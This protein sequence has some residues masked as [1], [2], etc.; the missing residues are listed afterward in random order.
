MAGNKL[1]SSKERLEAIQRSQKRRTRTALS[2]EDE[3]LLKFNI[4]KELDGISTA[5]EILFDFPER[6]IK[7]AHKSP[8]FTWK[9]RRRLIKECKTIG[10]FAKHAM[11]CKSCGSYI[12]I[13]HD[14]IKNSLLDRLVAWPK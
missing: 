3:R 9:E 4:R 13:V 1:R 12:Q 6:I 5:H 14:T 10:D 8:L 7:A 11:Y 2:N